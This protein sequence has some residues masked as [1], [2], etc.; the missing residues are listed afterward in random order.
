MAPVLEKTTE[1]ASAAKDGMVS[2]TSDLAENGTKA[3][4]V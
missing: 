3:D 2:T 1:I 4:I